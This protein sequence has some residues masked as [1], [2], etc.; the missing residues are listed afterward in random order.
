MTS[1]KI[2]KTKSFDKNISV[3]ISGIIKMLV[4]CAYM[5]I[6]KCTYIHV[7]LLFTCCSPVVHLLFTCCSP[8]V[9]LCPCV[10]VTVAG[11][12]LWLPVGGGLPGVSQGHAPGQHPPEP[13]GVCPDRH[14]VPRAARHHLP[15][16]DLWVIQELRRYVLSSGSYCSSWD[17]DMKLGNWSLK[18]EA[19]GAFRFIGGFGM[20]W[21]GHRIGR[22]GEIWKGVWIWWEVN[23]EAV[24][25]IFI[26]EWYRG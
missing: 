26:S 17:G 19:W 14:Q 3:L 8:V 2:S 25:K 11:D 13:A 23:K 22:A 21:K 12:V 4:L 18:A 10:S 6:H 15:H 24:N 5:C 7:H 20:E 1:L 16:R 9:H